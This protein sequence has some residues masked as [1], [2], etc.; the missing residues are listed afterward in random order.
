MYPQAA[1]GEPSGAGP[2]VPH[3]EVR[4]RGVVNRSGQRARNDAARLSCT[5]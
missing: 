5:L 3:E 2:I 4:M 1:L